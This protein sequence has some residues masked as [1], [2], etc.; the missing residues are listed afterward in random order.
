MVR[1]LLLSATLLL[2]TSSVMNG[3]IVTGSIAGTVTDS[4]GASV[5]AASVTLRRGSTGATRNTTTDDAGNFTIGA[6]EPGEYSIR[7][8]KTGFK[9]AEQTGLQL[10]TGQR[11]S[12]GGL[13]LEVGAVTETIAVTA[14]AANVQTVGADRGDLVDSRQ[15]EDLM[16]RGRNV[17][18]LM[19]LVPGVVMDSVNDDIGGGA[20]FNVQGS[21]A[22]SNN[23]S[24]DGVAMTDMGNGTQYKMVVSQS[25]VAEVRV[26]ISNYQAEFGRMAGSNVQIVTKSG[27]RAF[28]GEVS[29]FKRHEQFNANNFFNNRLGLPTGRYRYNTLT[30]NIG[31]PVFIPGKFNRNRD[32]L[33][34]FWQQEYW[35]TH[36][37]ASGRVT[38]PTELERGGDFTRTLDI[39]NRGITTRDP[40]DNRNP[41]PGNVIPTS[42]I[43]RNGQAL[44]KMF[45][46]P[47][48]LDRGVSGGQYNFVFISNND[49][50]KMAQT[51]KLDYNLNSSNILTGTFLYY[52]EDQTGT[53]G[54]TTSSAN[55]PQIRKTWSSHP[56][57]LSTR[58]TRVISPSL[59]NEFGF[60]A[61]S[62]PAWNSASDE[63]VKSNLRSTVGFNAG[64]LFPG[65]NPQGIIPNATYGG[66]TGAATI[67]TEGRFPLYNAY[68]LVG[69]SDNITYTRGNHTFK[70]GAYIEWFYR[71]Q[72]KTV[73][74]NGAFNFGTNANNPLDAGFA[75]ANGLLGN[76]NSYTESSNQGWMKVNTHSAEGFVQDTWRP[77][78]RLTFD[79]GVRIYWIWPITEQEN[80]MAAFVPGRYDPTQSMQLIRPATVGGRRSGVHPITGAVYPDAAVGAIAPGVGQLFNGM[81]VAANDPTYPRGMVNPSGA[82]FGPRFGFVYNLTRDASTILRGGFGM[83][84]DRY[85]T[86]IFANNYI[87]QPPLVSTPIVNYGQISTLLNSSGLLYPTAVNGADARGNLPQ[88]MNYSFSLQRTWWGGIVLDTAYA[89]SLGR[90]LFWRRDLNVIPLGANFLPQ[91]QDPTQPGRPLNPNFERPIPGYTT[92][93]QSEPGG[94]SNY[95]S[96]QVSARRRFARHYQFG[97]AWTWSKTLDYNDADG[98][99]VTTLVPVRVWNYG[100]ASFD[101]THVLAINYLVDVPRFP[102]SNRIVVGALHGWQVSG[103]TRFVSGQPVTVGFSSTTGI[104]YTGTSSISAR[105]VVRDNPVLPKGER[106]FSRNYRTDVFAAPAA[107]TL[108]NAART[109]LRGPGINNWDA[110]LFKN[111]RIYERLRFQFR[112]EAYNVFNHTQFSAM[113][114]TARFDN[115]GAQIN[116]RLS[117]FTAARN[118]RQMQMAL[119]LTF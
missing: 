46:Q 71:H 70:A 1:P 85:R 52:R 74:F 43:D 93:L 23:V 82:R 110:A 36:N 89:G 9:T 37:S 42:R 40:L 111:F 12:V 94:S 112:A 75:Y 106:T 87:G 27:A 7:A 76:F 38:V 90:R 59:L 45:P 68:Y 17:T 22:T 4:S 118:P 104:D 60:S 99:Q 69:F 66:V 78:K 79:L 105:I 80:G 107:G 58:Y 84:Y 18:D 6:L 47:N 92:I 117:E 114:N 50:P 96:L 61:L 108:G 24:V 15:I 54:V 56:K 49:L 11:L 77:M 101:R 65:A 26:L 98:D 3:Q 67:A 115:T 44:M 41:F 64:Q 100:L 63:A 8:G 13:V 28:H 51:F 95:H 39:N 102:T 32:K 21:R 72:K 16:V 57:S 116:A 88:I 14:S 19:Q 33:F 81:V 35:P 48:F 73:S 20:N 53:N 5:P 97:A 29:Y 10:T 119:R 91:N 2:F 34:F 83:F 31:G 55:W 103:I 25:A 30:Y 113:D 86:E 109:I 62:Q